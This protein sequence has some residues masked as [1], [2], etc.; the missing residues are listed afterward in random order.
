M[1]GKGP[2]VFFFVAQMGGST[3]N[4]PGES[5]REVHQEFD[6]GGLCFFDTKTPMVGM[7]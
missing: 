5:L 2:G 6:P 1:E 7:N 4:L 3:T